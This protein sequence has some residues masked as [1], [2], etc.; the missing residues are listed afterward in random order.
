MFIKERPE[1]PR[2]F[3]NDWLDMMTR[4]HWSTVPILYLPAS[5]GLVYYSVSMVGVDLTTSLGLMVAGIIAWT[6][7]EYFLHRNCT[8]SCTACTTTGPTTRTGW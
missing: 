6:L 7:F 2:I 8:S 4:T 3:E 5:L 1:S